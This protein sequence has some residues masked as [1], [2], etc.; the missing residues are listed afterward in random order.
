[1]D[2]RDII[3]L[4]INDTVNDFFNYDRNEDNFLPRGVIEAVVAAEEMTK[5]EIV[6]YF[7]IAIE[8]RLL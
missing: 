7:R 1:M 4:T 6:N 5:D 2:K 3:K 8:E